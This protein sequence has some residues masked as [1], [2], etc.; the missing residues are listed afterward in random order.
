LEHTRVQMAAFTLIQMKHTNKAIT[1][2]F[3]LIEPN[4]PSVSTP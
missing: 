1:P 4:M 3:I 2:E